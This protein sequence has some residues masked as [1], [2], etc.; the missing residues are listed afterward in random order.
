MEFLQ[1]LL[2]VLDVEDEEN[3]CMNSETC[4]QV[5]AM[6]RLLQ[7]MSKTPSLRQKILLSLKQQVCFS[8]RYI[9]ISKWNT[10]L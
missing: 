1:V 8:V 6:F 2:H 10:H 3:S 4:N 5:T 9:Y 7:E